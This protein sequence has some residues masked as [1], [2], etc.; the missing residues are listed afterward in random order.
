MIEYERVR[1]E[2]AMCVSDGWFSIG[3]KC[4]ECNLL[5]YVCVSAIYFYFLAV[6]EGN[7]KMEIKNKK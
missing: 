2:Q 7:T 1:F 3:R 5:L 4:L 6:G